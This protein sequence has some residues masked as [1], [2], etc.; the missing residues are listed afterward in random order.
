M[1][2]AACCLVLGLESL[3]GHGIVHRDLKPANVL[4]LAD[5]YLTLSDFGLSSELG[6]A[7]TSELSS[8][9]GSR[10]YWAPEV[11]RKEPQAPPLA[12]LLLHTSNVCVQSRVATVSVLQT[13]ETSR[14]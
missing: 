9:R 8:R 1:R 5:G 7:S 12:L 11:V 3:H 10:G 13:S 4:V 14:D 6:S 2:W